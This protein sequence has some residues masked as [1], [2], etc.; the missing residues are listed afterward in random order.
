MV[1]AAENAR[2]VVEVV[3]EHDNWIELDVSKPKTI[4]TYG[5]QIDTVCLQ[6]IKPTLSDDEWQERR[7]KLA[8]DI[9]N[10]EFN[11]TATKDMSAPPKFGAAKN[12]LKFGAA[13][14]D[15][16]D[17]AWS[18][19][20]AQETGAFTTGKFDASPYLTSKYSWFITD[21]PRPEPFQHYWRCKHHPIA[22]DNF[23]SELTE[24]ERGCD[25]EEYY[26]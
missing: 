3:K 17:P 2:Y 16:S 6:S 13:K 26:P 12:Q 25:N 10:R 9:L 1:A 18:S 23:F 24:C 11:D 15:T 14:I 21:W 7:E 5:P 4:S 22:L 8:A 19:K 20:I